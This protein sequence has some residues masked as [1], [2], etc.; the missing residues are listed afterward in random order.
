MI[1]KHIYKPGCASCGKDFEEAQNNATEALDIGA[2]YLRHGERR[3]GYDIPV[4]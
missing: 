1:I 2:S 4:P 3:R